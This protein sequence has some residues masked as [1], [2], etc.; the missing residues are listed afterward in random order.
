MKRI[1]NLLLAIVI[2]ILFIPNVVNAASANISIKTSGKAVVGNTITATVTVSSGTNMGS[3]QFL[4]SYDTSRL[5][6]VSGQ[7]SV[8]DYTT[9]A[10]G[11][12]SKSYTLKFQALKSGNAAINVGSYLVYAIDE[13]QMSVATKN[14]S[15]KIMTQAELEAT[16]SKDNNLKSLSVEGYEITPEFNKDTLEYAATVPSTVDKINIIANKNDSTASVEGAGEKEV[17]EGSNP[18]EIVVTAQNGSTKTYKLVVTV[19]DINPIELTID[20]KKYSVVKRQDNLEKPTGFDETT[21]KISEFDI[22]GF[23]SET[24]DIT[25]VGIKDEEGKI[26]LAIYEDGKY[27]EYKELN[28]NQITLYLLDLPKNNDYSKTT[29]KIN[30]KEVEVYK[31]NKKSKYSL[32]YGKNVETGKEDYYMYDE[33]EGTFQRYNEE[34]LEELNEQLNNYLYVI[35]AFSG[36]LGLIFLCF[37]IS[38]CAKSKAKKK[39]KLIEMNSEKDKEKE[40][41]EIIEDFLDE[42]KK[43]KSKTKKK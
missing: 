33:V 30:G 20:G 22:P 27:K 5:K 23:K 19:E 39:A 24:L 31:Y 15:V 10:A 16:Y 35:Y 6:L 8:A 1:K 12:K 38:K 29:I 4:V 2:S 11:V 28:S 17:V 32:V 14:A 42:K 37:I 13:S 25:L 26:S 7:T 43:S 3:W 41:K 21:V 34:Q 9:S 36:C 40:N 18:F